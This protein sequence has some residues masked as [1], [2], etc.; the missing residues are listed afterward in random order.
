MYENSYNLATLDGLI[1]NTYIFAVVLSIIFIGIS[2][3]VASAIAYEG[4]KEPRDPALRRTWFFVLMAVLVVF[5]FLW[6]FLYV[7][8]LVKGAPAQDSFLL[9]AGISTAV[10]LVVYFAL[11]FLLSKI[12]SKGKYG[13]I[14]P[15]KNA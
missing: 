4:G 13:T 6:N 2:F 5:Y 9:H 3:G 11:G 7:N 15:S 14:F 10:A 1:T 12:F 8:S